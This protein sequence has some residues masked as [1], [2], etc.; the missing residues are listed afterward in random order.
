MATDSTKEIVP[1]DVAAMSTY[2]ELRARSYERFLGCMI[3]AAI[4][5][6]CL[7]ATVLFASV[8]YLAGNISK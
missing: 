7:Q 5:L 4:L 8:G 2:L 6:S 3:I 1:P